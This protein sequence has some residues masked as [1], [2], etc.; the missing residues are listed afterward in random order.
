MKVKFNK[1]TQEKILVFTISGIILITFYIA[2]LNMNIISDILMNLVGII[3]PFIIGFSIAFLLYPIMRYIEVRVLKK[4]KLKDNSKKQIAVGFSILFLFI[5]LIAFFAIV[6]P[7]VID[8]VK[9]LSNQMSTYIEQADNFTAEIINQFNISSELLTHILDFGEQ[10]VV[11]S[12]EFLTSSIPTIINYSFKAVSVIFSSLLGVVVAIYILYDRDHFYMQIK[13]VL[14]VLFPK[15]M[16]DHVRGVV[17]LS[18]KMFNNFIV[19]KLIDSLIIGLLCYICMVLLGF[20]FA[21]LI[22]FIVG[23]TNVIPIFG[24]FIGAVPGFVILFIVNPI[25]SFWFILF[26]IALQQFDGNILG[27]KI[28]GDSMGIPTL[29]V[30]FAIVVGGGLFGL[31]GMFLGVPVFSVIYILVKKFVDSKISQNNIKIE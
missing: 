30:M 29:Y 26:I 15:N 12:V 8:S 20:E 25:D 23:C 22:S 31:L 9:I 2:I 4:S 17:R 28:L 6:I 10:L 21:M 19:G 3:M 18:S 1:E 16:V 7:Q 5:M 14:Y 13:K 27:P 11:A 24:P